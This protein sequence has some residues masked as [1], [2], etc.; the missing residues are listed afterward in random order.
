MKIDKFSNSGIIVWT[1]MKYNGH[2]VA[3]ARHRYCT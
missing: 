1:D 2:T 3:T